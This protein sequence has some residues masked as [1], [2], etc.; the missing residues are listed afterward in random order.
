MSNYN[1]ANVILI[2]GCMYFVFNY[3][4]AWWIIGLMFIGLLTLTYAGFIKERK[5]Y[6]EAEIELL[7]AK[8]NYYKNRR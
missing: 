1:I 4:F 8:A 5:K 2:L 6:F 7:K 3:G